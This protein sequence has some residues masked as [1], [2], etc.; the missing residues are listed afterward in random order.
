MESIIISS[1]VHISSVTRSVSIPLSVLWV[2]SPKISTLSGCLNNLRH[3]LM[4]EPKVT[5]NQDGSAVLLLEKGILK[6]L[7]RINVIWVTR[8]CLKSQMIQKSHFVIAVSGFLHKASLS[9]RS[10]K[11]ALALLQTIVHSLLQ[12]RQQ[13][14]SADLATIISC[15][16]YP[17]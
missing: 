11:S 3:F 7:A 9:F 13:C 4:E 10:S 6:I 5:L 8:L 1:C 14:R 15:F 16:V 12:L 2:C 17:V